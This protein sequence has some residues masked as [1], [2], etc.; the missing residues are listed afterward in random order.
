[1]N[2]GTPNE[3]PPSDDSGASKKRAVN[4]AYGL[5]IGLTIGVAF[6]MAMDN[7]GIGVAIGIALGVAFGTAFD[8]QKKKADDDS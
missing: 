3:N 1:M 6:G 7:I 8:D 4:W 2:P 5:P